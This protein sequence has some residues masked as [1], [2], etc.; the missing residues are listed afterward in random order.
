MIRLYII[1][2]VENEVKENN[3]PMGQM[4]RYKQYSGGSG[5]DLQIF[6]AQTKGGH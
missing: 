1:K 6:R 3:V 4:G 2:V 5:D